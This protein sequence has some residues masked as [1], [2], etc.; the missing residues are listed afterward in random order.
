MLTKTYINRRR[1]IPSLR[2]TIKTDHNIIAMS[3]IQ[4]SHYELI[5][6][7]FYYDLTV[8]GIGAVKTSFNTS[9]GVVID[10]VDPANLVYSYTDSPYF[11]DI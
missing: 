3:V 7:R 1:I 2:N 6:K 8:L 9:E 4:Y 10:Y 5:K 11:E